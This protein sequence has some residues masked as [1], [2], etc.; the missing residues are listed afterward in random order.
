MVNQFPSL[1]EVAKIHLDA[2][3]VCLECHE[4][5][6]DDET[7][8][9]VSQSLSMAMAQLQHLRLALLWLEAST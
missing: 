7:A 2:V 9:M 3:T 4:A 5:E 8:D 6:P 1:A